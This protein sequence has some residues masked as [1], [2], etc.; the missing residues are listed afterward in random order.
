MK[1]VDDLTGWASIKLLQSTSELAE[2][3]DLAADPKTDEWYAARIRSHVRAAMG[4]QLKVLFWLAQR[5][6]SGVGEWQPGYADTVAN[7]GT[8]GLREVLA[9]AGIKHHLNLAVP[10]YPVAGDDTRPAP[11]APPV[12]V[13]SGP[14][15][16]CMTGVRAVEA[17]MSAL[18]RPTASALSPR[19]TA[20]LA[21]VGERLLHSEYPDVVSLELQFLDVDSGGSDNDRG[22][23]AALVELMEEKILR[24]VEGVTAIGRERVYLQVVLPGLNDRPEAVD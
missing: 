21:W 23:R 9:S 8:R 4:N 7:D 2:L 20:L 12:P 18:S 15:W 10:A 19:A 13:A 1:L 5:V 6:S 17:V 22:G 11:G 14:A 3:A 16:T 24:R